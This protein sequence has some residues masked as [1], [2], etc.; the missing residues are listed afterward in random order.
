MSEKKLSSKKWREIFDAARE[1]GYPIP[2]PPTSGDQ[3]QWSSYGEIREEKDVT[4]ANAHAARLLLEEFEVR[5]DQRSGA[6]FVYDEESG[7]YSSEGKRMLEK[8]LITRLGDQYNCHRSKE[9]LHQVKILTQVPTDS[10]GGSPT[11]LVVANGTLDWGETPDGFPQLRSHSPE[12]NALAALPV[13]FDPDATCPQWEEFVEDCVESGWEDTVQEH[14]GYGLVPNDMPFHKALMLVGDGAN[15][16][17]QFLNVVRRLLGQENCT[18]HSLQEVSESPYAREQLF[19]SLANLHGDLSAAALGR[20][21]MFKTLVGGDMVTAERKYKDPFQFNATTKLV[22][23]ANQVPEVHDDDDAFF[24]R[25]L[26]V[27]FPNTFSGEDQV[28][29]IGEKIFEEEAS[30]ILNWALE[31]R[32]RL[33][34]QE[35]FTNDDTPEEIRFR[36]MEWGNPVNRF[37]KD[38]LTPTGNDDDRLKS[39]EVYD[40]YREYMSWRQ[41]DSAVVGQ[42]EITQAV[43]RI[44]Q[45]SYSENGCRINGQKARGF[46]GLTLSPE[47]CATV[48]DAE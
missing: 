34:S 26:L 46:K 17:S 42:K 30:G 14:V 38:C 45:V 36:W 21:N 15:G 18:S 41:E 43:K 19:R 32:R 23:A 20:N 44:P 13:E 40:Q 7:I 2:D 47:W 22:F 8:A 5:T 12:D 37:I 9:I 29:N 3:L 35:R 11:E 31:G 33:F 48:A 16:K 28:P 10:L 4:A 1:T 25:W 27:E 24:R 6:M 39:K